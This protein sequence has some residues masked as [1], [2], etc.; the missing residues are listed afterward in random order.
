MHLILTYTIWNYVQNVKNITKAFNIQ[1]VFNVYQKRSGRLQEIKLNSEKTG[2]QRTK[3]LE[4]TKIK[5][6]AANKAL[7]FMAAKANPQSQ[8]TRRHVAHIIVS[9]GQNML[10]DIYIL[11]M[12]IN[13]TSLMEKRKLLRTLYYKSEE[14]RKSNLFSV[15]LQARG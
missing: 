5:K 3:D 8:S 10:L 4:S 11:K 15:N 9:R 1:L 2:K 6:P 7:S 12:S 13:T 14:I